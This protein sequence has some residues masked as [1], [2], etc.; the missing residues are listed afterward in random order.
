MLYRMF[1]VLIQPPKGPKRK[2]TWFDHLMV[3][4]V[5]ALMLSVFA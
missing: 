3:F 2:P 1:L 5:V 4:L